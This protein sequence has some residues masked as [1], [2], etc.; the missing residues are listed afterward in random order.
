MEVLAGQGNI[1][2]ASYCETQS[3]K[4]SVQRPKSAVTKHSLR[5]WFPHLNSKEPPHL[6]QALESPA[7]EII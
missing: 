1:T 7:V 2:E 4:F 3:S 6:T 5:S